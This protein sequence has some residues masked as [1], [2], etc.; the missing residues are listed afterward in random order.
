[1]DIAPIYELQN[2]LRSAAIAGVNLLQEDFR[3]KRAAEAVKPLEGASPV[4]AKLNQQMTLLLSA[5]CTNPMAVLLDTLVLADAVIC[6]LGT[7]DAVGEIQPLETDTMADVVIV[8]AP[9]SKVKSLIEA[10]TTSGSGNYAFVRDMYKSSPEIFKD[11][12]V[13][14]ALVQALGA[15]YAE[16]AEMVK[17]W[18]MEEGASV[19][20]LLKKDFDPKGK[21]EMQRRLEVINAIAGGKENDFYLQMLPDAEKDIRL[22]LIKLLGE[23]PSNKDILLDMVNTEKGRNKQTVLNILAGMQDDRIDAIFEKM[24]KKKPE[25]VCEYLLTSTTEGA[26]RI[27]VQMCMEQLPAILEM[28]EGQERPDDG[29]LKIKRFCRSVEALIGKSGDDVVKCYKMLLENKEKLDVLAGDEIKYFV[30]ESQFEEVKE[31]KKRHTWEETI[32]RHLAISLVVGSGQQIA[33]LAMEQYENHGGKRKNDNFLTAAALA[34]MYE[35]D[36]C[37]VWYEEQ[38]QTKTGHKDAEGRRDAI[39]AALQ[40]VRWDER[41][42]GYMM[43]G[44]VHGYRGAMY[45]YRNAYDALHED[46]NKRFR[47]ILDIPNAG[48]I[49][50][51]MMK[52]RWDEL[53]YYWTDR[54]N[55][56][57]CAKMGEWFYNR[58]F[59]MDQ[60]PSPNARHMMLRYLDYLNGYK[61]T[62]CKG[63]AEV[64]AMRGQPFVDSYQIQSF[65]EKLPGSREDA[66][67]EMDVFIKLAEENKIKGIS[68]SGVNYYKYLREQIFSE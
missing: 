62:K 20:P 68:E 39:R 40:Y 15:S 11:Y 48:S 5:D 27:I 65:F 52:Y 43:Y 28:Q 10:L 24:A 32:G 8:N 29:K 1:M 34:K 4:F 9:C 47:R 6:T 59:D 56:A 30:V 53:I 57:E 61:W 35:G 17:E 2:R 63:L 22:E 3:L 44:Y 58:F 25:D 31:K 23:E 26:S 13:R 16:L 14:H 67:A 7:V 12:R 38:I 46:S 66:K 19:L 49:I 50:Q 36:D 45:G 42:H 37:T 55:E 41:K 60:V 18:L 33:A 54:D 51:W 21:K 64:F